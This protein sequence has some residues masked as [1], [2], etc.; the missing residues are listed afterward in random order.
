[1]HFVYII[2]LRIRRGNSCITVDH[3]SSSQLVVL[4]GVVCCLT[5]LRLCISD[6]NLSMSAV[7]AMC[8]VLCVV[9]CQ[10]VNYSDLLSHDRKNESGFVVVCQRGIG[11]SC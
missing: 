4:M 6:F 2:D 10:A 7:L 9:V 8:S 3:S 1:M 5:H 11:L